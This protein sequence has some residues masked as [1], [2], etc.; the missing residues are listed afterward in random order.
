LTR[1]TTDEAMDRR[2]PPSYGVMKKKNRTRVPQ[3][4]EQDTSQK[5]KASGSK[6]LDRFSVGT[7]TV[8]VQ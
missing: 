2:S 1:K 6:K 5:K 8:K 4:H 7:R 3:S